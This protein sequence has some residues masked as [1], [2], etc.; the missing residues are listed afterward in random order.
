MDIIAINPFSILA[1][2]VNVIVLFLIL[3]FFLL[4]P[5]DRILKEREELIEG[6]REKVRKEEDEALSLKKEYME[7]VNELVQMSKDTLSDA[8]SR[9]ETEY[10]RIIS[11]ANEKAEDILSSDN[12]R[13]LARDKQLREESAKQF[14]E[15]V[16]QAAAKVTASKES[17]ELDS[18]LYDE[19]LSKVGAPAAPLTSK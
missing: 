8:Q 13:A 14:A 9:A 12:S 11:E 1:T 7:K 3:K 18:R 6:E 4:K 2:V 16:G 17:P 19:F 5:I 15:L 10:E